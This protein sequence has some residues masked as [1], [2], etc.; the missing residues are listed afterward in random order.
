MYLCV[1]KTWMYMYQ[2]KIWVYCSHWR[3]QFCVLLLIAVMWRYKHT[4]VYYNICFPMS[5]CQDSLKGYGVFFFFPVFFSRQ[6][7][8][9][10]HIFFPNSK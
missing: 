6:E 4:V 2:Y 1:Y 9:V 5:L 10:K 7:T 3:T 8:L